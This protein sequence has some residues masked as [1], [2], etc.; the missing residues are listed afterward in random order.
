MLDS[1]TI[2]V[3]ETF[4]EIKKKKVFTFNT[5]PEVLKL[6]LNMSYGQSFSNYL[7]ML[8]PKIRTDEI[9]RTE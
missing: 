2:Y 5:A 1:K 9:I 3:L 6:K 7:E 8:C 4:L